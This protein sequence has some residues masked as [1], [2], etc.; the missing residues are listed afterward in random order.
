MVWEGDNVITTGRNLIGATNS[1]NAE[2]ATIRG[3]Y[4]IVQQKNC[5][6]GSDSAESASREI[7]L[8]F[9]EAQIL[10]RIDCREH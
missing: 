1:A 5:I 3:T 2:A 9:N 6:H 4:S 10:A 7:A 8:W